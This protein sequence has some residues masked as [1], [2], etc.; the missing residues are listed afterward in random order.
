MKER[1]GSTFK[2]ICNVCQRGSSTTR[3]AGLAVGI[4]NT[5]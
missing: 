1:W 3:A 2:L 5:K 4:I